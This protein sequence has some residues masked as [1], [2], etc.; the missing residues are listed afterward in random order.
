P[1]QVERTPVMAMVIILQVVR[2]PLGGPRA[3]PEAR[4]VTATAQAAA[5]QPVVAAWA[6]AASTPLAQRASIKRFRLAWFGRRSI[7]P[8]KPKKCPLVHPIHKI[9][10]HSP[11]VAG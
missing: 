10:V 3:T 8:A 11:T 2:T 7:G 1:L 9:P 6:R 4:S 5:A